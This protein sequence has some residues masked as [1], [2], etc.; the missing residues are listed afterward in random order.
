VLC[1]LWAN[2]GQPAAAH[3]IAERIR[4]NSSVSASPS[5]S[6]SPVPAAF[7]FHG[8]GFGHGIGLSQYGAQGMATDGATS[9]E[10]IEHYFPGASLTPM[11][12]PSNLIVGLLQDRTSDKRRFIS[13]RAESVGG[14][15]KGLTVMLGT[16]KISVAP[17]AVITFGVINN[18]IV[19]YGPT[20]F[21]KMR[22]NKP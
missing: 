7:A 3:G 14:R 18:Q 21:T 9:D 20:E 6:S 10:I 1:S 8:A 16:T 4:A 15:G 5:A 11:P 17:K 2:L 13:L 12:M 22:L 19:A